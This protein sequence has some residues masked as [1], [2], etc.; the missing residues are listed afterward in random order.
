MRERGRRQRR[1]LREGET[2]CGD[3]LLRSAGSRPGRPPPPPTGGSSPTPGSSPGRRCRSARR[4]S[5]N[6]APAATV[7]RNGYRLTTTRSNGSMPRSASCCTCAG[8]RVSASSPPWIAGCRVLTRPS[9][10]SGN[11]VTCST[12]VTGS[13]A[14]AIALAEPPVETSATPAASS[15]VASFDQPGLVGHRE[16][17]APDRPPALVRPI[18]RWLAAPAVELR[19]HPSFTFRPVTVYGDRSARRPPRPAAS[20]RPP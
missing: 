6:D 12:G 5:S 20:A 17:R 2:A 13:P 9:R 8:N 15:A 4:T 10:H 14:S 16:Q 7:S 1:A 19:R 11:P 18:R 3:G